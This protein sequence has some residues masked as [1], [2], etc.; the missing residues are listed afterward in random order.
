MRLRHSAKPKLK[1]GRVGFALSG[2]DGLGQDLWD[3]PRTVEISRGNVC[4][5]E[6]CW[7][8]LS[9]TG[10]F[11][12]RIEKKGDLWGPPRDFLNFKG[13]ARGSDTQTATEAAPGWI[14]PVQVGLGLICLKPV[15]FVPPG[16][17]VLAPV[18]FYGWFP[19]C[20]SPAPPEFH[21]SPGG[22]TQKQAPA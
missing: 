18:P 7:S 13:N 14:C 4:H 11:I 22:I 12:A 1:P 20:A 5:L 6:G 17:H 3:S 10:D 9:F 2:L 15:G 21:F 16:W 8:G 19:V